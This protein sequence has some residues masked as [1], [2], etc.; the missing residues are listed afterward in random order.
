GARAGTAGPEIIEL[1]RKKTQSEE[2]P[3]AVPLNE[4]TMATT[5]RK[6]FENAR[7]DA[8]R[9]DC[10]R[11]VTH[12][13]NGL[14]LFGNDAAALNDLGNCYRKLGEIDSAETAFKRAIALSDSVYI[15][16]N[17]AELHESQGRFREPEDVFV[18]AIRTS[19]KHG[20]ASYGLASVYSHQGL[21]EAAKTNGLQA[22][23]FEHKIADVHLLLAKIY[24]RDTDQAAVTS[25]LEMYIQ[26]DPKS[27]L[28]AKVKQAL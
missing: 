11:A 18:D 2:R 1:G 3:Q 13:E 19:P 25:Q 22:S 15:A 6:E 8:N 9:N 28:S 4:Y 16:L 5:A 17:L 23:S 21:F 7:K 12:F 26:E 27:P 14:R 24:L 10:S 20:D